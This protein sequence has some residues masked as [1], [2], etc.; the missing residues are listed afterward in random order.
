MM[1][2]PG[3]QYKQHPQ[4]VDTQKI[5]LIKWKFNNHMLVWHPQVYVDAYTS[6]F[7]LGG[8]HLSPKG[9]VFFYP[10]AISEYI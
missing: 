2:I 8:Q 7:W 4:C 9:D 10:L 1:S 3:D 6:I 5:V